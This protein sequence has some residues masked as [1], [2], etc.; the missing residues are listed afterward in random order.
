MAN[1]GRSNLVGKKTATSVDTDDYRTLI[2]QVYTHDSTIMEV[3]AQ[4]EY[5]GAKRVTRNLKESLRNLISEAS[6]ELEELLHAC[7]Y[8]LKQEASKQGHTTIA[9]AALKEA[10]NHYHHS[11]SDQTTSFKTRLHRAE[12]DVEM[13]VAVIEDEK[14]AI[15]TFEERE[16]EVLHTVGQEFI[17]RGKHHLSAI[18]LKYWKDHDRLCTTIYNGMLDIDKAIDKEINRIPLDALVE[19]R[20]E[21]TTEGFIHG[22]NMPFFHMPAF[23]TSHSFLKAPNFDDQFWAYRLSEKRWL[24]SHTKWQPATSKR[25]AKMQRKNPKTDEWITGYNMLDKSSFYWYNQQPGIKLKRGVQAAVKAKMLKKIELVHVQCIFLSGRMDPENGIDE[26]FRDIVIVTEQRSY[27]LRARSCKDAKDWLEALVRA[28]KYALLAEDEDD[29]YARVYSRR[30]EPR[31]GASHTHDELE[32]QLIIE[33]EVSMK[34]TG[35]TVEETMHAENMGK[36]RGAAKLLGKGAAMGLK[37][38]SA[39]SKVAQAT[40]LLGKVAKTVPGVGDTRKKI[41]DV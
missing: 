32:A 37:P 10:K 24:H 5:E 6:E 31:D 17:N 23:I 8:T 11:A 36:M 13:R 19:F 20:R 40:P 7:K 4:A 25:G 3:K 38:M 28:T 1:S 22:C 12:A 21:L 30:L 16:N 27:Q 29:K 35:K 9:F 34:Q 39:V 14:D 15:L 18:F 33:K 41:A 2:K 26:P